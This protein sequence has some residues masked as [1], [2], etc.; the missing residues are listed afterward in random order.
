MFACTV[1]IT[2]T[3]HAGGFI[4]T[5]VSINATLGSTVQFKCQI[6]SG[7]LYWLLNGDELWTNSNSH[8]QATAQ[9]QNYVLSILTIPARMINDNLT[10]HCVIYPNILAEP[11]VLRVQGINRLCQHD[12]KN[13]V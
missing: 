2:I 11:A 6:E 4:Q 8:R 9:T 7:Q 12:K 3:I 10:I 1:R 5:P 13:C